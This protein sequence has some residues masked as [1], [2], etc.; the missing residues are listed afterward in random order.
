MTGH[1][2]V[3]WT[4][5][6]E[7]R[8][9][10]WRSASGAPPPRRIE[11]ADDTTTAD[12]AFRLAS[13]GTGLLWR[14]DYQ[15][16]RQ[17]LSALGRRID[18]RRSASR[19]PGSPAE[20]FHRHRHAQSRRARTLSLLLVPLDPDHVVPLRRAP[21]V[22]QACLEAYG[23][24]DEPALVPLRELLG[25]IG[26]HE[27]RKKGVPV[28]ALGARIHPHYGV[29]SPVRGE[30]VDL[31]AR[32]PLPSRELAFDVGAGTGVL[33]AVL[34]RRGVGRVVA[35][36]QD[37]RALACARDNITRLGLTD[38][39][40]VRHADLFPPGRAP[41]V[42]CNPPWVPAQP[43]SPL[44]AAVYDPGGRMLRAFLTRLP[45]H[46]APGGEA[47]LILS[48]LAEHLGLRTRSELLDAFELAGLTVVGRLDIA[49]RHRRATAPD[50]PLRTARAAEVT[51]LWRLTVR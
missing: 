37:A 42:V 20:A 21:D 36:D 2:V 44:E 22:R 33:A 6:G 29:F 14:G 12:A 48:D 7:P 11:I 18:R 35:T 27:W 15:N 30:Y 17:L 8:E 10:R 47:W 43:T 23:P 49:P 26:A 9:A 3:R 38:R 51:S 19:E 1:Q 45:G 16:A 46:L 41:L 28:P 31:V 40:V 25:V 24:A 50:D 4:E 5:A 32:A 13:A 39:V 34:A